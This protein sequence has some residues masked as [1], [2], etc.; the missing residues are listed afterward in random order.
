[1]CIKLG[2]TDQQMLCLEN[3][4]VR[5]P[6]A[7][8]PCGI[9]SPKARTFSSFQGSWT[10]VCSDR[11]QP[12]KENQLCKSKPRSETQTYQPNF[13]CSNWKLKKKTSDV[14]FN[15]TQTGRCTP[16]NTENKQLLNNQVYGKYKKRMDLLSCNKVCSSKKTQSHLQVLSLNTT[17]FVFQ[18]PNKESR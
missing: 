13:S 17:V 18:K 6:K 11:I 9:C 7:V 10:C 16:E 8:T 5:V 3:D 1:M 2:N 14:Q 4:S 15:Y 12:L